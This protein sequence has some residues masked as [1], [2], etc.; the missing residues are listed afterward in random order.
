MS[1]GGETDDL[2]LPGKARH[3]SGRN[4]AWEQLTLEYLRDLPRQ[5]DA[6]VLALEEEDYDAIRDHA[7]RMKGT[8]G[9]YRLDSIAEYL[10]RLER[11]ALSR[12]GKQITALINAIS[13]LVETEI[14]AMDSSAT[15]FDGEQ[16]GENR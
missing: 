9:T 1:H 2:S 5:L 4:Q 6:I 10:A 7:H 15:R 8:S 16:A 14:K 3:G 11:L 13:A 12:D